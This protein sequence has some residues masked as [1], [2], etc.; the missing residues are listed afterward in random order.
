MLC[1]EDFRYLESRYAFDLRE[2]FRKKLFANE[3]TFEDYKNEIE[4]VPI[5]FDSYQCGTAWTAS[6]PP[7]MPTDV[8]LAMGVAGETGELVEVVKKLH[9]NNNGVITDEIRDKLVKE[10][11]DV[12]YYLSALML[13]H[14]VS[15]E[16]VAK[17]NQLK[18][19]DRWKRNVVCSEGD[20]R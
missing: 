6:Y 20:N 2:A 19:V 4:D 17:T 3:I 12:L 16:D 15:M 1:R 7:S 10:A 13:A 14:G 5:T 18:L 9:R 11:G 8:Y